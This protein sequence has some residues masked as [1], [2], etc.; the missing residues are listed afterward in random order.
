MK[1][2]CLTF[3]LFIGIFG[4]PLAAQGSDASRAEKLDD[5]A[6]ARAEGNFD[7]ARQILLPM[8]AASPDDPDLLRRLA[9]V[10]AG[11]PACV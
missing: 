9:M 4:S 1:C 5:A 8:L 6:E 2:D 3:V 10:E 7:R 11:A